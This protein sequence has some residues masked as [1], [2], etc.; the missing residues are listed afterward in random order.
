MSLLNPDMAA[1]LRQYHVDVQIQ[2]SDTILLRN[3]P[4]DRKRFNK[5]TTNLL[6]ARPQEGMPFLICVDEDLE[7]KGGDSFLVRAFAGTQLRQG[8]R[9]LNLGYD[10]CLDLNDAL[11]FALETLG[12]YLLVKS[13]RRTA[14]YGRLQGSGNIL[15][16]YGTNLTRKVED[17]D[18][19]PTVGRNHEIE[20]VVT[21]ICG[22]Q[23]RL[24]LIESESG[25]GK[26]NMLH[27]VARALAER[28]PGSQVISINMGVLLSGTLCESERE[29]II[30]GLLH[31]VADDPDSIVLVLEHIEMAFLGNPRGALLVEQALDD[32]LRLAGTILPRWMS[33][34]ALGL[35][36]RRIDLVRLDELNAAATTEA[37]GNVLGRIAK[38]HCVHIDL[39]I[40]NPTI[41][42]AIGLAGFFPS[43]AISL[44]D[45]AAA[46]A[47]LA[48]AAEVE[49]YHVYLAGADFPSLD[50]DH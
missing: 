43:K 47:S 14:S 44:L 27:A 32:R 1:R 23:A 22:W 2:D 34:T 15:A 11:H 36:S 29:N 8:W 39:S 30:S 12:F 28:R 40:I 45:A 35:L 20:R 31:E 21:S 7:Y 19:E 49:I 5:Q 26:T 33:K 25:M 46:R 17:P 9:V 38:H 4:A 37:L 3:V 16:S 18:V 24:P 6:L 48:S 13:S 10:G 41:E 42:R 50:T